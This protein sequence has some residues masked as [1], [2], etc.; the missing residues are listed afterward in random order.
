MEVDGNRV[1]APSGVALGFQSVPA[2]RP[3]P[4]VPGAFSPYLYAVYEQISGRGNAEQAI[5][6]EVSDGY[7]ITTEAAA[8]LAPLRVGTGQAGHFSR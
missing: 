5:S 8:S 4:T 3:R 2:Q 7:G 1:T 6:L